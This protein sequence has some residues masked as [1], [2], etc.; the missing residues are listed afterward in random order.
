MATIKEKIEAYCVENEIKALFADG[1]DEA[2]V[3]LGVCFHSYKVIYNKSKVL[4]ILARDMSQE[5]AIMFFEFNVVG[6][7]V[8][9]ET[10]IFIEDLSYFIKDLDL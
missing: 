9:D 5:E 10:P 1:Y 6:A 7:Y 4:E 3:G 8:G 2:I